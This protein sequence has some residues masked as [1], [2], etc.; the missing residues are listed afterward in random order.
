MIT[1]LHA[2]EIGRRSGKF[3]RILNCLPQ[4]RTVTAVGI[5][6]FST[7]LFQPTTARA[8]GLKSF[9]RIE[10]IQGDS[11]I[12]HHEKEIEILGFTSG[13]EID[14]PAA[15][16]GGAGLARPQFYQIVVSKNVDKASPLLFVNCATGKT[17]KSASLAV[18]KVGP[19][20]VKDFFKIVLTN[21]TITKV[22][23][24]VSS[25]ASDI[26]TEN[27]ELSFQKIQWTVTTTNSKGEPVI[28][29]GGYD[30][31]TGQPL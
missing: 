23:T 3:I 28:T 26:L 18:A 29:T 12:K 10:G 25:G 21:V 11:T 14:A 30:I 16:G 19:S 27:V 15:G 5:A 6:C 22:A 1:N 2:P 31:F 17:F 24:S 4:F 7:L 9:L 20:S 13:V 8:Q